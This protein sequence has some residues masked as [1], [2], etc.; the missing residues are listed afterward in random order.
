MSLKAGH[1][2]LARRAGRQLSKRIQDIEPCRTPMT[3]AV[4]RLA[5]TISASSSKPALCLSLSCCLACFF[6]LALAL[7]LSVWGWNRPVAARCCWAVLPMGSSKVCNT[8]SLCSTSDVSHD[9][10]CSPASRPPPSSSECAGTQN[11]FHHVKL[12]TLNLL[13]RTA[14]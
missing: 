3:S 5:V 7:G 13:D 12:M 6:L 8:N 14:N 9:W 11:L 4:A 2:M 1:R 10:H